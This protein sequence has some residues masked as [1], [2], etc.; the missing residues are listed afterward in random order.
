MPKH[1]IQNAAAGYTPSS[2]HGAWDDTA[3]AVT[4]ALG[5]YPAPREEMDA[6]AHSSFLPSIACAETNVSGTWDVCLLR[7][8]SPPLAANITIDDAITATL[9]RLESST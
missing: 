5:L 6:P 7:L 4:R 9:Y 2:F 1:Y 8:V 3:V